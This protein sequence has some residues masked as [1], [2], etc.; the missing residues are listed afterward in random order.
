MIHTKNFVGSMDNSPYLKSVR[1]VANRKFPDD[2]DESTNFIK[3]LNEKVKESAKKFKKAGAIPLQPKIIKVKKTT[4]KKKSKSKAKPTINLNQKGANLILR[5]ALPGGNTIS[6]L[7]ILINKKKQSSKT[8][9]STNSSNKSIKN[10]GPFVNNR[11]DSG[12]V[13]TKEQLE[14]LKNKKKSSGTGFVPEQSINPETGEF[15]ANENGLLDPVIET[16][17]LG[18]FISSYLNPLQWFNDSGSGS[19]NNKST[20]ETNTREA[21]INDPFTD[22]QR[23]IYAAIAVVVILLI[24]YFFKPRL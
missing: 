5:G 3:S 17:S 13:L 20:I 7:S 24:Y 6:P 10:S 9:S 11:R 22:G 8:T 14:Q 18:G 15:V 19:D 23:I 1:T 21:S 16:N 4:S 2:E 12:M